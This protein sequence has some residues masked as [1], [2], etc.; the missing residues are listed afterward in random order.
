MPKAGAHSFVK[1]KAVRAVRLIL[2][3]KSDGLIGFCSNCRTALWT[4]G[5]LSAA[6]ICSKEG[7]RKF[8]VS[9][10]QAS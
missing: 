9:L 6:N 7:C 3:D 5:D 8:E 2:T 1:G 10:S 4:A